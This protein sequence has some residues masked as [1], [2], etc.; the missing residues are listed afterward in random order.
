MRVP[1]LVPVAAAVMLLAAPAAHAV[2]I[3]EIEANDSLATAQNI[4]AFFSLDFSADIGNQAGANTSTTIPHV[5]ITGTGNGTFDYYTFT[6]ATTSL[7]ILD[8]DYGCSD[9]V[10]ST[11]G[12]PGAAGSGG[13]DTEIALWDSTGAWL[14]EN[15]DFSPI[16]VGAGGTVHPYDSFIQLTLTPG[17]Y[18]VGVA[19]YFSSGTAGGWT[20]GSNLPDGGDT[21]TLQVSVENPV[22]EPGTLLLL[23]SG[24]AGIA[25][26]RRRR[27]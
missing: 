22:P 15:D 26:R 19:E 27:G 24:I 14:T 13:M 18:Y 6:V 10:G 17:V 7:V 5:T 23:G 21:Y 9:A 20:A 3:G 1:R 12:C 4:D 25:A 11:F 16:T 8:I 2:V